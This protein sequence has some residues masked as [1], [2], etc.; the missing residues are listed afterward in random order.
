MAKK[1][2]KSVSKVLPSAWRLT[3]TAAE[4]L[5]R[6]KKIF[7]GIALIYGLLNLILVQGLA[8]HNDVSSLKNSL[9][10]TFTGHLG[11]LASSLGVFAVLVGSAGNGSSPTA[12]AYQFFL[13]LVVSLA[14][15]W[16]LRQ[17]LAG[18][19]IKVRDAYYRG[20]Y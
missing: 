3:R 5:W 19:P 4:L 2:G 13:A 6:H 12:G 1:T 18:T 7:A 17:L 14:V 10:Q 20:M 8:G 16:A 15:I 11:S 9:N